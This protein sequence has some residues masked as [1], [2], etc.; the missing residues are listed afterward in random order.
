MFT[1][2]RL[3]LLCAAGTAVTCF[4]MAQQTGADGTRKALPALRE[5]LIA[6]LAA[7]APMKDSDFLAGKRTRQPKERQTAQIRDVVLPDTTPVHLRLTQDVSSRKARP[8]DRVNFEIASDVVVEG[9]LILALGMSAIGH[10]ARVIPGQRSRQGGILDIEIDST[11]DIFGNEIRLRGFQGT[12]AKSESFIDFYEGG[13]P[14][15]VPLGYL[16]YRLSPGDPAVLRMGRG[17]T[18]YV[19]GSHHYKADVLF[20]ASSRFTAERSRGPARVYVYRLDGYLNAVSIDG[21]KISL[22][23]SGGV[24]M[25]KVLPGVHLFR[26]GKSAVTATVEGGAEYFLQVDEQRRTLIDTSAQDGRWDISGLKWAQ[27]QNRL[28]AP[29]SST[30]KPK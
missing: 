9:Q 18:V 21:E 2:L 19:E 25:C 6:E 17:I 27:S 10:I 12:R 30:R 5:N 22:R 4:G 8:G 23:P 15:G 7:D 13:H 20:D 28:D 29:K 24:V 11:T 14:I 16:L 1:Y 26:A 3:Y